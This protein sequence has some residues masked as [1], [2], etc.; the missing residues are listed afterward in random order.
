MDIRQLLSGD[1]SMV[2]MVLAQIGLDVVEG[3]QLA[4][5]EVP[6][7][8]E[9]VTASGSVPGSELHRGILTMAGRR[10]VILAVIGPEGSAADAS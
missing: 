8:L 5:A 7:A 6:E 3:K 2:R 4:R 9:Q 1:S 10:I